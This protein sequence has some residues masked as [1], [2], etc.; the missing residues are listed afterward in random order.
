MGSRDELSFYEIL[1][2]QTDA[3]AQQIERAYR[4]A[5]ATYQPGSVATYSLF[6]DEDSAETLRRIENAYQVL[7]E[8]RLRR[9]Y[10]ARL[11]THGVQPS[12]RPRSAPV[13]APTRP[14]WTLRAP[15][16]V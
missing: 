9:E 2:V 11:R 10:D 16:A 1:E 15:A 12:G 13:T 14:P 5:R 4:I 3:T 7:S 6:S 8:T